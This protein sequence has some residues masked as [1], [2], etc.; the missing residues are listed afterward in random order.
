MAAAVRVVPSSAARPGTSG[1]ESVQTTSL[2]AGRR[3]R[4]TPEA[5][6]AVS[7]RIGLPACE[8]AAARRRR[9]PASRRRRSTRSTIPQAWIMRTTTVASAGSS[10]SSAASLRIIANERR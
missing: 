9:S 3:A 2:A 4:V 7:Q 5:T 10:P 8:R 1:C 6:I